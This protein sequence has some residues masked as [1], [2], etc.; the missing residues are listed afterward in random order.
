M[1]CVS[2]GRIPFERVRAAIFNKL[3]AAYGNEVAM[4]SQFTRA[5]G[6]IPFVINHIQS[7]RQTR[8]EHVAFIQH[9]G[10]DYFSALLIYLCQKG[11]LV[12]L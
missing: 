4:M 3:L 7:T 8:E 6:G 11:K 2:R 9:L 1:T 5:Y 10:F 12:L